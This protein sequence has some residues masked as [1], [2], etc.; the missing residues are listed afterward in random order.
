MVEVVGAAAAAVVRVVISNGGDTG[1]DRPI[2][3]TIYVHSCSVLYIY[4][5]KKIV[6]V[7]HKQFSKV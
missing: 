6:Y 7:R 5:S 1:T 2:L 4:V 3:Y